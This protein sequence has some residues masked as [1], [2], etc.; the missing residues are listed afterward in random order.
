MGV[1]F[2]I[3]CTE[4]DLFEFTIVSVL[5]AWILGVVNKIDIII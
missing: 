5:L 4:G 1:D 2:V 3:V